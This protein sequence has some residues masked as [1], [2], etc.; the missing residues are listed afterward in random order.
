MNRYALIKGFRTHEEATDYARRL[1]AHALAKVVPYSVGRDQHLFAVDVSRD[2]VGGR[3][4][5]T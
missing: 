2:Y 1:P 4:A 3:L 5:Q